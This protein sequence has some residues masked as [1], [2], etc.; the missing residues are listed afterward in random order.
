MSAYAA[1]LDMRRSAV[2]VIPAAMKSIEPDW[3]AAFVPILTTSLF[4][5]QEKLNKAAKAVKSKVNFSYK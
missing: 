4:F 5:E 3:S 2:A 1:L